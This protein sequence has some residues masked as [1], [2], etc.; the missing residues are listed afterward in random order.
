MTDAELQTIKTELDT[1]PLTLG[2]S[3]MDDATAAAKLR[4]VPASSE[5]GRQR[6]RAEV[7]SYE[8]FEATLKSEWEALG[9]TDKSLYDTMLSMGLINVEGSN[10]RTT[11]LALF[12]AGTTTRANLS[13]LQKEPVARFVVLG[14]SPPATADVASA[15][16]LP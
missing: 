7:Q 10:T 13:A 15:R 14:T 4:E 6:N 11:F 5:T 9:A 2:Y 1:D 8:V 3:G 16:A 12:G